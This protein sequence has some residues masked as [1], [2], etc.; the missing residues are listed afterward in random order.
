MSG[1][2][3]ALLMCVLKTLMTPDYITCQVR[4]SGFWSG[5]GWSCREGLNIGCH[6]MAPVKC[7]C[8]RLAALHGHML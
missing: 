3:G 5:I 7:P 8:N 4:R 1:D 2:A 6:R